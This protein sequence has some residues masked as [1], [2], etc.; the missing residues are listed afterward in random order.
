MAK[1]KVKID[2]E[3]CIGCG[4]C[5]AVCAGNFEL[6]GDKAFVKKTESDLECNKEAADIC[7]V[8]AITV[9]KT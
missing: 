3:K 8:Q 1:Y 5:V 4:S 6:K 7:P 2:K 9:K